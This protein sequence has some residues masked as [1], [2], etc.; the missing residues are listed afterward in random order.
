MRIAVPTWLAYNAWLLA[1][2]LVVLAGLIPLPRPPVAPFTIHV[3][4]I[5]HAE[6]AVAE[7]RGSEP[8]AATAAGLALFAQR[9][10]D[11]PP[12][13]GLRTA[14]DLGDPHDL[15]SS[16]GPKLYHTLHAQSR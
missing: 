12:P 15:L 2:P 4:A 6:E 10:L 3:R 16:L 5:G 1:S 7:L 13:P 14:A 8:Y 11:S 9:I